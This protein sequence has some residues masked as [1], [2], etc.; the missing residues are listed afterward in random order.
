MAKHNIGQFVVY[1]EEEKGGNP[2]PR[3]GD[4]QR[5]EFWV[6]LWLDEHCTRSGWSCSGSSSNGRSRLYDRR[7]KL[8]RLPHL[9]SHDGMV[10]LQFIEDLVGNLEEIR[11]I[12]QLMS[13]LFH[14]WFHL[15]KQ[16]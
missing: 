10:G 6:R 1:E 16:P 11:E 8:F 15:E 4:V 7:G 3:G 14:F 5:P 9:L 13:R 12:E 2:H